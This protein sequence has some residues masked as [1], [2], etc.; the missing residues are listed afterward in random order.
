MP[1]SIRRSQRIVN[2][3]TAIGAAQFFDSLKDNKIAT[4][5]S[6]NDAS[7]AVFDSAAANELVS[8][9]DTNVPENL[10]MV[11]DEIGAEKTADVVKAI[12][13]GANEYES[14]H[15]VSV[16][17]DVLNYAFSL[18]A[19]TTDQARAVMALDSA[20]SLHGDNL[21]MQPNRAVIAVYAALME[22]IPFAHYLPVD[23]GSNEAKLGIVT[24]QAGGH[25][26]M[27]AANGGMDGISS[28]DPY[29]T[30]SR[31]HATT[32]SSGAHTGQL[33]SVQT[34]RDTCAAVSGDVVAVKLLRGRT[35]V[36]VNGRIV[37]REV[38]SAGSGLSTVSGSVVISGTTYQIGGTVN[39]DTGAI[40]LTSTPA[41]GDS[42]PV[43]VEGFLDYDR[44]PS[45]TPTIVTNA[46]MF[47]IFAKPWQVATQ[48]G[49][50]SRTQM[51]NE[52]GLDAHCESL[53]TI[54]SQFANERHYEVLDKALRLATYSGNTATF[55]FAWS[56]QSA[57]KTRA[58]VLQDLQS[59][60]GVVSQQM[61]I[62][63]MSYG[64]THL[65]VGKYLGA[66]ML[67]LP[68]TIW[69]PSG[70]RHRP[71]IYRLGRLFG[72][73]DVYYTPK[74]ITESSSAGQILCI[75]QAP[76][77]ARNPFVLGDA[78]PPTLVVLG[79]GMDLKQG[80]G[81]YGR[82]F[83]ETNPH[84]PSSMGCALINV[85]NMGL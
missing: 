81:F 2:S 75:G 13:C 35:Q 9:T 64:V 7:L 15:G 60:L 5:D 66:M 20:N 6:A 14:R 1:T 76:D 23:I 42:V 57:Q 22:A 19:G 55:D 56:T 68:T 38:S 8:A 59:H 74:I 58:D 77:V 67:G 54:Q 69:Q 24:H 63:T 25:F 79:V 36:Y 26:G 4:F 43:H 73:Y 21:S 3:A 65:Y 85:T 37:A 71:S 11:F 16:P 29:I 40:A 32:N 44:Q 84:G 62:D 46:E 53:L 18:A 49:M 72:L 48:I 12:L 33:T 39:T 45:L 70:V 17:A 82:N 51:A 30:S 34:D 78:V 10:Q 27:Y 83:T 41:L 28:G 52:L 31:I 80:N 50:S 61:A 47:S